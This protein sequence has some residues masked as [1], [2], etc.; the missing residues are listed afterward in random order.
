VAEDGTAARAPAV[1]AR[2]VDEPVPVTQRARRILQVLAPV[3]GYDAASIALRDP[4]RQIRIPLASAGDTAAVHADWSG[5][6]ADAEPARLGLNRPG[7]PLLS[8]ELSPL[9]AETA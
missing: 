2:I 8:T 5:A 7:R 4:E 6:Q 1:I 3:F 9:S